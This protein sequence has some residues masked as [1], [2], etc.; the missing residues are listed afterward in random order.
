M[1]IKTRMIL[2][3]VCAA[4]VAATT[5]GCAADTTNGPPTETDEGT[6]GTAQQAI[7][8]ATYYN[9]GMQ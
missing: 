7:G 5:M 3:P 2:A 6:I 4:L 1:P 8:G 9:W